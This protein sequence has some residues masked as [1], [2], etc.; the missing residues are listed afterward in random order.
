MFQEKRAE[1]LT[2]G[3]SKEVNAIKRIHS[4]NIDFAITVI[5]T[6]F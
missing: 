4:D 3:N 2:T 6:C 1:W 5:E